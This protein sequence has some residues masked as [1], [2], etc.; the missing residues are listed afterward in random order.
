MCERVHCAARQKGS[1]QC[2]ALEIKRA[3][4]VTIDSIEKC[5]GPMAFAS[6]KNNYGLGTSISSSVHDVFFES[7]PA[8]LGQYCSTSGDGR[9]EKS[10]P[11]RLPNSD[12]L[13]PL[14]I[15]RPSPSSPPTLAITSPALAPAPPVIMRWVLAANR[16][17]EIDQLC[18]V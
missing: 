3:K 4:L 7:C 12:V 11:G 5:N 13:H 16:Q 14:N 10:L 17:P 8:F 6:T 9:G 18:I 1:W 15:P 2:T